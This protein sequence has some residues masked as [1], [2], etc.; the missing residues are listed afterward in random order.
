MIAYEDVADMANQLPPHEKAR[1]IA[2]LSMSLRQTLEENQSQNAAWR[3][4]L[5]ATFGTLADVPL[6]RPPQPV[7][8]TRESVE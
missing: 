6:E 1:L 2:H 3:E 4:S 7:L 5:L 8:E